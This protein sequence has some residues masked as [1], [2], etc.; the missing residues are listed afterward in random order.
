[1]FVVL[2]VGMHLMPVYVYGGPDAIHYLYIVFV[3]HSI[4]RMGAGVKEMPAVLSVCTMQS[5]FYAHHLMLALKPTSLSSLAVFA[6]FNVAAGSF[7][8]RV[9]PCANK[10]SNLFPLAIN[11]KA[12]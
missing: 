4:H 2:V 1:M 11:S 9:L 5:N 8:S 7:C 12:A 3:I 10:R 6:K